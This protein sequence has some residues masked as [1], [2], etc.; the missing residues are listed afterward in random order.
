LRHAGASELLELAIEAHGGHTR[1]REVTRITATVSSGGVLWASRGHP[2]AFDDVAV[3][4]EAHAQSCS[5]ARLTG[6]D[7]RGVFA[8]DRVAIETAKGQL[9]EERQNPRASFDRST[10]APWDDIHLA[11]FAG[12][13]MWT[14]LT[15]PFLLARPGFLTEELNPSEEN[16]ETRRTLRVKFPSHITSHSSEQVFHFGPDGLLRRRDYT[17][18]VLIGD[19][20]HLAVAHYTNDH[21]RYDGISFPTQRHAVALHPDGT[22]VPEPVLV[23]IDINHVTVE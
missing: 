5:M 9:I 23:A 22:T 4:I 3:T 19:S 12:Y 14:Y 10:D 21:K 13:A 6:P 8:P 17:P 11:Y 1:W 15:V 7:R 16:G 18:E 20:G 2:G